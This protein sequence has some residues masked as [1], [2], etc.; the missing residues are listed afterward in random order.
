MS[1]C[2]INPKDILCWKRCDNKL[3]APLVWAMY[4]RRS[5]EVS[6]LNQIIVYPNRN[7]RITRDGEI[8]VGFKG[9]ACAHASDGQVAEWDGHV[10]LC[11]TCCDAYEHGAELAD[12]A[13][14]P[15][16]PR[17]AKASK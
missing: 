17:A 2:K 5:R 7:G 13:G 12:N 1:Q 4:S 11:E 8:V 15:I 9:W 6:M 14:Q 10:I 16:Q 3:F